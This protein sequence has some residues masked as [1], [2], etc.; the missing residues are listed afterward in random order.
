MQPVKPR[1]FLTLR[2]ILLFYIKRLTMKDIKT[3]I[4]KPVRG[5]EGEFEVS[6]LGN[7]RSLDR[8]VAT[9]K[10]LRK[11]K[12]K[13]RKPFISNAGYKMVDL[14]G[15]KYLVH[16][17]V[18]DA[19]CENPNR[20]R[21]NVVDHINTN[22]LD[23]RAENLRWCD[24]AGNLA[25]PL[26]RERR[27][28][29]IRK[30]MTP[31]RFE[32]SNT[33]R[34]ANI[35]KRPYDYIIG[36]GRNGESLY[37]RSINEASEYLGVPYGSLNAVMNGRSPVRDDFRIWFN[38]KEHLLREEK[39]K[40][41]KAIYSPIYQLDKNGELVGTFKS[42][43]AAAEELNLPS[44]DYIRIALT[45]GIKAY[46]YYWKFDKKVENYCRLEEN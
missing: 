15:K 7:V 39:E 33:T 36:K 13:M 9:S 24:T 8:Y 25:N 2:T 23:N 17:L 6:D 44:E 42:C 34:A 27:I 30:S 16:R 46:G 26:S 29:G 40:G 37:F 22:T 3:E 41:R 38:G 28:E 19:F 10:G 12:G 35:A 32:K 20:E 1:P 4:W 14:C 45:K 43:R 18:A 11:T 5:Y 31:E 21:F